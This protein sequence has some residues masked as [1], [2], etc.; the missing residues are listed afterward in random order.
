[1]YLEKSVCADSGFIDTVIIDVNAL[2]I[3]PI[4]NQVDVKLLLS[5]LG[6]SHLMGLFPNIHPVSN[7]ICGSTNDF[8]DLSDFFDYDL[9]YESFE[10]ICGFVTLNPECVRYIKE[11]SSHE[12]HLVIAIDDSPLSKKIIEVVKVKGLDEEYNISYRCSNGSDLSNFALNCSDGGGS[13]THI[14]VHSDDPGFRHM[15]TAS[16]YCYYVGSPW[17][18]YFNSHLKERLLLRDSSSPGISIVV[19]LDMISYVDVR[20]KSYWYSISWRYAGPALVFFTLFLKKQVEPFEKIVFLS[21]DGYMPMKGFQLINDSCKEI[22]YLHTSRNVSKMFGMVNWQDDSTIVS[23]M[24]YLGYDYNSIRGRNRHGICR[25][26]YTRHMDELHELF[27][28]EHENYSNYVKSSLRGGKILLV[29]STVGTFSS[30]RDIESFLGQSVSG[31]YYSVLANSLFDHTSFINRSEEVY[32]FVYTNLIE[33]FFSSNEPE[34]KNVG[35]SISYFEGPMTIKQEFF[36]DMSSGELDYFDMFIH[37]VGS[38]IDGLSAKAVD[39]WMGCLIKDCRFSQLSRVVWPY[40]ANH[41]KSMHLIPNCFERLSHRMH[42]HKH[43]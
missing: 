3:R 12:S 2:F 22:V 33:F 4:F 20:D 21:R 26:F 40:N 37:I 11:Y 9:K 31:C 30:Q 6:D 16:K 39:E 32:P 1:M 41:T 35:E 10:Y 27:F 23:Y 36:N 18:E 5:G 34:L 8:Y 19:F 42:R 24:R 25:D 14:I 43:H 7:H 15:P 13:H 28:S 38:N 29:D 17:R